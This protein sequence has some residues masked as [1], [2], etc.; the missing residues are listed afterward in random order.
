MFAPTGKIDPG[1]S[2]LATG[3]RITKPDRFKL[4]KE[5]SLKANPQP[6]PLSLSMTR[7]GVIRWFLMFVKLMA[8]TLK[9]VLLDVAKRDNPEAGNRDEYKNPYG[10]YAPLTDK[11]SVPPP[12]E[13]KEARISSSNTAAINRK[14]KVDEHRQILQKCMLYALLYEQHLVED[15]LR[16]D[17]SRQLLACSPQGDDPIIYGDPGQP[18]ISVV[19]EYV[20]AIVKEPS[21]AMGFV[22]GLATTYR[23]DQNLFAWLTT[24]FILEKRGKKL[25]VSYEEPPQP[26]GEQGAEAQALALIHTNS[27]LVQEIF[28]QSL[29]PKEEDLVAKLK[30]E[31]EDEEVSVLTHLFEHFKD[32]DKALSQERQQELARG[33]IYKNRDKQ[34]RQ[35]MVANLQAMDAKTTK[36]PMDPPKPEPRKEKERP[37][38]TTCA[39]CGKMHGGLCRLLK[40]EAPNDDNVHE[41]RRAQVPGAEASRRNRKSTRNRSVSAGGKPN[42]QQAARY[43]CEVLPRELLRN[44]AESPLTDQ[45]NSSTMYDT[46]F[47]G[48]T[49]A[50]ESVGLGEEH[51]PSFELLTQEIGV[52]AQ[53]GKMI[54]IEAALDSCSN[55]CF[56]YSKTLQECELVEEKE[57]LRVMDLNLRRFVEQAPSQVKTLAGMEDMGK[58]SFI[59]IFPSS[60][61]ELAKT[62]LV[63]PVF[64]AEMGQLPSGAGALMSYYVSRMVYPS[65][66]PQ[67]PPLKGGNKD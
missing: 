27:P 60:D 3:M 19:F 16:V 5:I 66:F 46:L 15:K 31:K 47:A 43:N 14:K 24:C 36:K 51:N 12:E 40:S 54:R 7:E 61:H 41:E 10:E 29:S 28:E 48:Q 11:F 4:P 33:G 39:T 35:A 53:S 30:K 13:M 63:I 2:K 44:L 45:D 8:E 56:V 55:A 22:Q 21:R 57:A 67:L 9:S 23:K 50:K 52:R 32:P 38:R 20:K 42:G 26:A 34:L 18:G 37:K 59:K 58:M 65:M 25:G 64:E 6:L 49:S 62:G 17:I 1:G